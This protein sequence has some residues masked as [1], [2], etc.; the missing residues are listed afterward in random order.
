[1]PSRPVKPD[2]TIDFVNEK[3]NEEVT[4][5]YQYSI[6][7]LFTSSNSGSGQPVKLTPGIDLFFI[8]KSTS[9][10]FK[11]EIQHLD[12]PSRPLVIS[13]EKDTTRNNPFIASFIFS[14]AVNGF[15]IHDIHVVNGTSANLT[16]TFKAEINPSS[17][18]KVGVFVP[19]NVVEGGNF[20]S[21][22]FWIYYK[23][24]SGLKIDN[25]QTFTLYPNPSNGEVFLQLDNVNYSGSIKNLFSYR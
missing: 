17:A 12:V 14:S 8:K 16:G 6:T 15:D 22:N 5:E 1:M 7:E 19:A 13:S 2:F 9:G 23:I 24:T 21:N 4:A 18:G 10:S 11:S 25:H 20:A 3:T